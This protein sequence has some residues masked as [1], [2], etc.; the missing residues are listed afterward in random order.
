MYA[1]SRIESRQFVSYFRILSWIC[2]YLFIEE[3]VFKTRLSPSAN[4]AC[5]WKSLHLDCGNVAASPLS[6]THAYRLAPAVNTSLGLC[7]GGTRKRVGADWRLTR[8]NQGLSKK[9][10]GSRGSCCSRWVSSSKNLCTS[11]PT[12][13]FPFKNVKINR[14]Q[15]ASEPRRRRR[16]RMHFAGYFQFCVDQVGRTLRKAYSEM[17]RALLNGSCLQLFTT[18]VFQVQGRR[19]KQPL[20]SSA[21]GLRPR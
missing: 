14:E 17:A 1:L 2:R 16:R 9:Q 20:G 5:N 13:L 21:L 15:I 4:S 12:Y 19:V 8:S 6:R 7:H 11:S 10:G 3:K 18:S